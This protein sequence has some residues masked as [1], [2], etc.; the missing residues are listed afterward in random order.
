MFRRIRTK[1][2]IVF[3]L[4]AMITLAAST[5]AGYV[6]VST[7]YENINRQIINAE[8]D[9]IS[10][11]ITTLFD[12]TETLISSRV[13]TGK[14]L[15]TIL[16]YGKV[17]V[18]EFSYAVLDIRDEFTNIA[19]YFE[20]I[21]SMYIQVP[22]AFV[23]GMSKLN[24]Q[25]LDEPARW[26]SGHVMGCLQHA[27]SNLRIVGN[28]EPHEFP[29][30]TSEASFIMLYRS[31]NVKNSQTAYCVNVKESKLEEIY[32]GFM[33][34]GTRNIHLLDRTGMIL[35]SM[36]KS[37]IGTDY[38][39]LQGFNLEEAGIVNQNGIVISYFPVR[40]YGLIITNA[41]PISVYTSS[42]T[43]LRNRMILAFVIGMLS[44]SAFFTY[45]IGKRLK[46]IDALAEGMK[47]AG[48]GDYTHA[49]AVSGKDELMELTRKYNTMLTDLQTM[50]ES[51]KQAEHELRER[52][53]AVLR[54]EI[55][56]HF[57]YNTLNTIKCMAELDGNDQIARCAKA[58]GGIVAPLYKKHDPEWT[59]REEF[60]VIDKYLTIMNI[61]YGDG[62]VYW[63]EVAP[64]L[65]D[66]KVMRFILQPII[67]N[68]ILHGFSERA[69]AGR[70]CIQAAQEPRG[71]LLLVD[72]DG[73]GM[74]GEALDTYNE[75]LRTGSEAGGVGMINVSRRIRLRYGEP[76]GI[77]L[78]R[79]ELG[80]LRTCILL[81]YSDS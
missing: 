53:L 79:S 46:P 12:E 51:R 77:R 30:S 40:K 70:I 31:V 63:E 25:V 43:A 48:Q 81:P 3:I 44:I 26:P 62:I 64:E 34:D 55:N 71:L 56:P 18:P 10:N 29:F 42:L 9:Q 16:R 57:L 38:D 58:L 37:E 27:D 65:L 23:L 52:E 35:S 33:A 50:Q 49:L 28:M 73:T 6:S 14:K 1:F 80:G 60:T 2:L 39:V 20:W 8:F 67:E 61:R 21:D 5:I 24:T 32:S 22:D 78:Q 66:K 17:S 19:N 75:A 4:G 68:S 13:M 72:D 45:W 74:T 47:Y 69:Y 36:D 54:N 41:I 59:L 7:V 76:Y 11:E 15:E